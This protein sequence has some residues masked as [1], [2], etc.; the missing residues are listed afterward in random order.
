MQAQRDDPVEAYVND[1]ACVEKKSKWE[2]SDGL[3]INEQ[4]RTADQA[5]S[6]GAGLERLDAPESELFTI[7]L[8][9]V[10]TDSTAAI[11]KDSRKSVE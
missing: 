10:V 1:K 7:V 9:V 4:C 2:N 8:S 3:L 6:A 5:N 11:G